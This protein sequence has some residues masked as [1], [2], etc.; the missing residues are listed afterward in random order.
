MQ[1]NRYVFLV[2]LPLGIVITACVLTI[3]ISIYHGDE[4]LPGNIEKSGLMRHVNEQPLNQADALGLRADILYLDG[5]AILTLTSEMPLP[6]KSVKLWF[7][8][9]TA[10][11]LDESWLLQPLGEQRYK[12]PVSLPIIS[13][14]DFF[15]SNDTNSWQLPILTTELGNAQPDL[16][17]DK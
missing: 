9:R 2:M 10:S 13:S 7:F 14:G 1:I 3:Y 4:A 17:T 6:T 16:R 5:Q 15:I 11:A 12:L 8:H